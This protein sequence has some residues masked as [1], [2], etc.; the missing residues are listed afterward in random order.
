[1]KTAIAAAV[2][3]AF[4]LPA[5]ADEGEA[6]A[7][8]LDQLETLVV[9]ATKTEPVEQ[10]VHELEIVV[11]TAPKEQPAGHEISA[12]TAALLAELEQEAE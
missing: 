2:L 12:R 3:A 10:R 11:S 9:T 8:R 6:P 7:P 4:A 1:M 5:F